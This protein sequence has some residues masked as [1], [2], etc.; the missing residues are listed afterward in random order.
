MIPPLQITSLLAPHSLRSLICGAPQIDVNTKSAF[1][2]LLAR[3]YA[4]KTSLVTSARISVR[5]RGMG[6]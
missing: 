3:K 2:I 6:C 5:V 4:L 1:P